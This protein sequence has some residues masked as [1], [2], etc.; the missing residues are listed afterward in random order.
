M[1]STFLSSVPPAFGTFMQKT[2]IL[3]SSPITFSVLLL[4]VVGLVSVS[5]S[6]QSLGWKV[7]TQK[8]FS[9]KY[10][11]LAIISGFYALN[12]YLFSTALTLDLAAN[13]SAMARINIIFQVLLAYWIAK[14][15]VRF[16]QRLLWSIAVFLG[17]LS[18]LFS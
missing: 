18:I 5:L 11:R 8:V 16:R 17:M 7:T 15:K 12:L 14:Q 4:F 6:T 3:M 10:L 2:T 13:V 9:K 1:P